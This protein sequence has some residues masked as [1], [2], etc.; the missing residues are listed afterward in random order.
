MTTACASGEAKYDSQGNQVANDDDGL[1]DAHAYSIISAVEIDIG[2]PEYIPRDE[3][4]NPIK[5][6]YGKVKLVRIRNPWGFREWM[7]DWSDNSEQWKM[8]PKAKE[9]IQK[10]LEDGAKAHLARTGEKTDVPVLDEN[11]NDGLFW[12]KFEDFFTYYQMTA[13]CYYEAKYNYNWTDAIHQRL[14]EKRNSVYRANLNY[15]STNVP[16]IEMLLKPEAS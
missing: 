8:F 7:G 13:I 9:T 14:P 1:V 16:K 4:D 15:Q 11:A 5:Y 3:N 12:M 2:Y 10:A 6:D